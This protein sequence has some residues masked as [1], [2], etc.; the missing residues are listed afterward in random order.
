MS[1][2]RGGLLLS[3]ARLA[4]ST[5]ADKRLESATVLDI[6][7]VIGVDNNDDDVNDDVAESDGTADDDGED[8]EHA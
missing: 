8:A 6:D 3:P 7:D 2:L 1:K 5:S 4:S